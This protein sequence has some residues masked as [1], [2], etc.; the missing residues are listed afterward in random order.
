M[1]DINSVTI[2][3]RCTRDAEL[4]NTPNGTPILSIG[5]ANNRSRKN[6]QTGQYEDVPG[7]FDV[8]VIGNRANSLSGLRKG[9]RVAVQ[10]IL[11][12]RQ[13]EKDGQKHSKVE[14]IANSIINYDYQKPQNQQ[15]APQAPYDQNG[16]PNQ[17]QGMVN[18]YYKAGGYPQ[19]QPSE[20]VYEDM[21]IP[22]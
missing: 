14:I 10:G 6:A 7:F 20:T 16:S 19:P 11:S 21:E 8:T 2:T 5:I 1:N 12:Y 17:A 22:F 13:W 15:N 9:N 4:R 3:G 18:Q